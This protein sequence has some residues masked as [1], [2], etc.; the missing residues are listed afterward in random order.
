MLG[1]MQLDMHHLFMQN[2]CMTRSAPL[3]A[4]EQTD[5]SCIGVMKEFVETY[6][7][8]KPPRCMLVEATLPQVFKCTTYRA[9]SAWSVYA[10]LMQQQHSPVS[11]C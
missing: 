2:S 5:R 10:G 1:K 3:C 6:A 7:K 9:I 11:H 8:G 4:C